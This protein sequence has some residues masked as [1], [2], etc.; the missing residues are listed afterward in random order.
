MFKTPAGRLFVR[1][2]LRV[3]ERKVFK[4]RALPP[5]ATMADALATLADVQRDLQAESIATPQGR[6]SA[7]QRPG[8][9]TFRAYVE[10]WLVAKAKRARASVAGEW[11]HRLGVHILPHLGDLAVDELD[12]QA[13]DSWVAWA[14]KARQKNGKPYSAATVTGWYRLLTQVVKDMTADFELP[15]PMRRVIAPRI[16]LPPVREHSTLNEQQILT[17]LRAARTYEPDWFACMAFLA[18]TGARAGEALG[19]KWEDVDFPARKITLRRAASNGIE[20]LTKTASPREV[21]MHEDLIEVLQQHRQAQIAAQHP[22]LKAGLVFPADNGNIRFEQAFAKPFKLLSHAIQQKVTPQVLRR[23]FNTILLLRG[24]D[25][26]TLRSIMGHTSVEMTARY[27]GVPHKA[28]LE[29]L[30]RSM[31]RLAD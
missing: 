21:P 2:S 25:P 6:V 7:R 29:A 9:T 1:A 18:W 23:S 15:D 27:A 14:E 19:L 10:Q 17:L 5:E 26:I 16:H 31:P 20:C 22:G 28:K 30:E 13:V 3:G 11:A 24:V 8:S 12:R 4:E